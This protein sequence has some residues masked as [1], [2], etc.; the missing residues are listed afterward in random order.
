MPGAAVN[1]D[2]LQL[3]RVHRSPA[4]EGSHLAISAVQRLRQFA[5]MGEHC[6]RIHLDTAAEVGEGFFAFPR[7]GDQ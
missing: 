1:A 3:G 7:E 2:G 5:L 6:Q 4:G